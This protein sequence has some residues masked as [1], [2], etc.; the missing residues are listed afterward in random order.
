MILKI[1]HIKHYKYD[2]FYLRNKLIYLYDSVIHGRPQTF[3]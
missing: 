3:F 1:T 2:T